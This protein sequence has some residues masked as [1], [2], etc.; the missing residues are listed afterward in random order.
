MTFPKVETE[1]VTRHHPQVPRRAPQ[2]TIDVLAS[3]YMRVGT[4]G[5]PAVGTLF[6]FIYQ[7]VFVACNPDFMPAAG[8]TPE[9][10][11]LLNKPYTSFEETSFKW[12][13]ITYQL[14]YHD[15]DDAEL[16]RVSLGKD[17]ETTT[18]P[19]GVLRDLTFELEHQIKAHGYARG[20]R[21]VS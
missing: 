1:L 11:Y 3:G 2:V 19:V 4:A 9:S 7:P 6:S 14:D 10:V 18:Y 12:E 17:G 16:Y 21:K 5:F 13:D 20:L 8:T 15:E